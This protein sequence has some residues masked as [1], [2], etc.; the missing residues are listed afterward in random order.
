M[1]FRNIHAI[2]NP[3]SGQPQPVL[4][5]MNKVFYEH[6]LDWQ[7]AVTT[8]QLNAQQLTQQA[9][10]EGADLIIAYG[11]DGTVKEVVSGLVNHDVPV[12][13]M[14]GGTGNAMANHLGIPADLE[15]ALRLIFE[16][17]DLRGVDLGR[18][19]NQ[20]KPDEPGYFMLRAS[21][22]LQQKLLET[23]SRELKDQFGNLAYIIAGLKSLSDP[24]QINFQ[25]T[26]DGAEVEGDGLMCMIVNS[27]AVGG[28]RG[29][30]FA[31]EVDCSD[32]LLNVFILDGKFESIVSMVNSALGQ[33]IS[34]FPH[35]WQGKEICLQVAS[36]Q[37]TVL[38]GE[39]FAQTPLK[40]SV[41]PQAVQVI[42]PAQ[43]S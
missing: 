38:D 29:F 20:E 6:K 10:D 11:G 15:K 22:G 13:L 25:L 37:P 28:P 19:I 39:P 35:H 8:H 32:G 40:V 5:A 23:A 3:A 18:A 26:I 16:P 43:D 36:P 30:N 12:A 14:H 24:E 27:A 33:D 9:I 31:P 21:A 34:L 7:V 41:I 17:H 4:H 2:I 42:V 1:P